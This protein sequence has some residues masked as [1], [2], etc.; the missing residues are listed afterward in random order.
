MISDNDEAKEKEA[1]KISLADDIDVNNDVSSNNQKDKREILD[2]EYVPHNLLREQTHL[3]QLD[4]EE[5]VMDDDNEDNEP[6]LRNRRQ[7]NIVNNTSEPIVRMKGFRVEEA[8]KE[9]K[10]VDGMIPSV[11]RDTKFTMRMF[12]EG[13][14][15]NTMIAFTHVPL[16]YGEECRHLV[17][18]EFTV[19]F[20][21]DNNA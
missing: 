7:I 13:F 16:R 18:G 10:I 11:L 4:E 20:S 8:D 21:F 12:G 6:H 19:S 5:F 17:D 9:P 15:N 3:E 14:T 1:V 2:I